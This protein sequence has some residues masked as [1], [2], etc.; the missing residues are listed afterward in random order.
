[1]ECSIKILYLSM[2]F[3][4]PVLYFKYFKFLVLYTS[5]LIHFG[6]KY[7]NIYC[8]NPPLWLFLMFLPLVSTVKMVLKVFFCLQR[9]CDCDCG[10]HK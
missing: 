10:L 4:A 1:M 6:G 7:Y 8:R 5:I 3:E 2:I 9:Q